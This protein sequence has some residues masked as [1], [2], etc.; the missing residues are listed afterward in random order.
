MPGTIRILSETLCN[1]I[2]AGEVVE[3]PSSV[4]KELVENSL[5]AGATMVAVTVEKGGKSLIRVEDDGSGMGRDDLFLSLER[6]ATSKLADEKDLFCLKTL[7]FRG[8]ALP[9]IAAVSHMVLQS[10]VRDSLEGLALHLEGGEIRKTMAAGIPPG[11]S[12]EVHNLFF[13]VPARK[14]FLKSDATEFAHIADFLFRI[15]LS[16]PAVRFL[17]HHNGRSVLNLVRQPD[18]SRR[19]Y[20]LLGKDVFGA[21]T[22]IQRTREDFDLEGFVGSAALHRGTSAS[23]YTYVNRR[24]V[25]DR[26]VQHAVMEGYRHLLPRHRYPVAVIFLNLPPDQVDVNVHPAKREVR[27]RRQREVHDFI[28]EALTEA[29]RKS[30]CFLLPTMSQDTKS[31]PMLWESEVFSGGAVDQILPENIKSAESLAFDPSSKYASFPATILPPSIGG[32]SPLPPSCSAESNVVEGHFSLMRVLGQYRNSYIVCQNDDE[33]VLVDQHAAHERIGFEKLRA[34]F[35]ETG[36]E[37]QE[38]LFPLVLELE[39]RE[40][41]A[42][43]E[44]LGH[45]GG[46]GFDVEPY[47]K[48]SCVVRGL[49]ALLNPQKAERALK[50]V[51]EELASLEAGSSLSDALEKVFIRMACHGMVRANQALTTEE[52]KALLRDMDRIDLSCHCPHGRPVVKRFTLREIESMFRRN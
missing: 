6:H 16:F 7:G 18:L 21:M 42:L 13:N 3:R 34:Q 25:R 23:I 4:V 41:A 48:R 43:E 40:A 10:R 36:L 27:F 39:F 14:K 22:P 31:R 20:E 33:L 17:L 45:L 2:A 51:L 8:E 47:G 46:L 15:A 11:T 38:L 44:H 37:K 29:W 12:V 26:L 52:M 19:V 9:S 32:S 5:D 28:V 30:P 49:P 35:R 24:F 50:D 1:Q